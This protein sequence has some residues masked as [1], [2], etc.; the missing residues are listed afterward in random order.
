MLPRELHHASREMS[1]SLRSP[2]G[3]VAVLCWVS[4]RSSVAALCRV[5]SRS[6]CSRSLCR[7]SSRSPLSRFSLWGSPEG[8][9]SEPV[10]ISAESAPMVRVPDSQAFFDLLARASPRRILASL[11]EGKGAC[12]CGIFHHLDL[13]QPK[14]SRHLAVMREAKLRVP[15]RA[16]TWLHDRLY[17]RLPLWALR[18]IEAMVEGKTGKKA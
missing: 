11:L 5:S 17:R 8:E 2:Y 16:G 9:E 10:P 3:R 6:L 4:S 13:P 18:V 12:V 1:G 7:V 14:I 15:R